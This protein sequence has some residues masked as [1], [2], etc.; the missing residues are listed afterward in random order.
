M[1][2]SEACE[3]GDRAFF[4][5]RAGR[6]RRMATMMEYFD[7]DDEFQRELERE[8]AALGP[9]SEEEVAAAR[10]EAEGETRIPLW[11]DAAWEGYQPVDAVPAGGV[12]SAK[13]EEAPI[14]KLVPLAAA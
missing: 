12:K 6:S 8:L 5:A 10:S 1:S 7:D 13:G 4:E 9:L 3:A 11:A 2:K 14:S